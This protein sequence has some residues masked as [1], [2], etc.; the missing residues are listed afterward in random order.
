[1][2][3]KVIATGAKAQVRHAMP[4]TMRFC[5]G[6]AAPK[7]FD[8]GAAAEIVE[9]Y[10]EYWQ[11]IRFKKGWAT[12]PFSLESVE[13]LLKEAAKHT[14]HIMA[15][16]NKSQ[17]GHSLRKRG[18]ESNMFLA[19]VGYSPQQYPR[20]FVRELVHASVSDARGYVDSLTEEEVD[21]LMQDLKALE[22]SHCA[23]HELR[24]LAQKYDAFAADEEPDPERLPHMDAL[25]SPPPKNWAA[26]R[27]LIAQAVAILENPTP[28]PPASA[29]ASPPSQP[30]AP[31]KAAGQ[32][33]APPPREVGLSEAQWEKYSETLRR[34]AAAEE[35][36]WENVK[37]DPAGYA[38]ELDKTQT[39]CTKCS[40][41]LS[42]DLKK[43]ERELGLLVKEESGVPAVTAALK[44][45]RE[46]IRRLNKMLQ[47]VD[48]ISRRIHTLQT[49]VHK[50]IQR[51]AAG[52][53]GEQKT[54]PQQQQQ[55]KAQQPAASKKPPPSSPLQ[56][57]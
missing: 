42:A 46:Q 51:Q 52:A 13:P 16:L 41:D 43:L 39:D 38:E 45:L 54:P 23:S 10:K 2:L 33:E 32:Q 18:G 55:Q 56:Q 40:S 5:S 19:N 8:R 1:M 11:H 27:A 6:V 7:A 22:E 49:A 35:V 53:K 12:P 17:D 24:A 31:A 48:E 20:R 4:R 34:L 28:P 21:R 37:N 29:A 14:A 25:R 3:R 9:S 26:A 50:E 15:A 44:S 30:G 36:K 47:A 57:Q